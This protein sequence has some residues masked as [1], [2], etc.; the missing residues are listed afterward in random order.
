MFAGTNVSESDECDFKDHENCDFIHS[1]SGPTAS[2]W[3]WR[4]N[5][6]LG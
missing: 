6:E 4:T 5:E 3:F 2:G 1:I